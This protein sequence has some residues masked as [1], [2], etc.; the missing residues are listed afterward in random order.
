MVQAGKTAEALRRLGVSVAISSGRD[1][2]SADVVHVFN[3]QTADWTLGQVRAARALGKPVVLSPIY[4]HDPKLPWSALLAMGAVLP[5]L[6]AAARL[7]HES[8]RAT[9][10]LVP[11]MHRKAA[12]RVLAEVD[13]ILPNSRVEADHLSAEFPGVARTGRPVLAVPNGVDVPA[14]DRAA[15]SPPESLGFELP[16]SFV[17]CASRIDYRKNTLAL[18]QATRRLGLPLVVAGAAVG[19]TV[20]HRAYAA[21]CHGR[22][23]HVRFLG[24][25]P[26]DRLWPL[27][28]ACAVHALPS[29][30]ETPGLS[31]LEAALAGARIVTTPH[32]STR[33]YFG[34]H[35]EYASPRS[36]RSIAAALERSLAK[37][38][39][40]GLAALVREKYTWDRAAEVTLDAYRRVM[41]GRSAGG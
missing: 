38:P 13:A 41:D 37:P 3:L 10:P 12:A 6:P 32:G 31:S 36:V 24:P 5:Y 11:A 22:G 28:R 21:A 15:G 29:F 2:A 16:P 19:S 26:Q 9:V 39:S 1:L 17:L 34:D 20:L 33:E 7:P 8:E 30:F 35:A 27:Y 25:L 23:P 40:S 4:W 18:I 14:F